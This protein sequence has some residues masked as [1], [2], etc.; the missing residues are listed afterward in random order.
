MYD[1]NLQIDPDYLYS[2]PDGI[3]PTR[4]QNE[5]VS[6]GEPT[7]SASA[8]SGF[9]VTIT[10]AGGLNYTTSLSVSNAGTAR[11]SL[12]LGGLAVLNAGAASADTAPSQTGS[13]VQA[14]VQ[15]IITELRDLK[16]KLRAAG[17][18]AT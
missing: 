13:Y 3:V 17:I 16:T 8:S 10:S 14:D 18:I 5:Q 1:I 15:A 4:R 9:S 2:Q 7:F 11:T 6:T 12:G